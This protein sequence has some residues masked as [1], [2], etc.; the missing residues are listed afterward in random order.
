MQKPIIAVDTLSSLDLYLGYCDEEYDD[1][2]EDHDDD[3][4]NDI[5]IGDDGVDDRGQSNDDD[6]DVR[7]DETVSINKY[8]LRTR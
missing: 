3:D 2:V 8:E 4:C 1:G 7:D 5:I 6:D